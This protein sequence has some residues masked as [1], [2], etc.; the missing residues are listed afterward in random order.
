MDDIEQDG[1]GWNGTVVLDLGDEAFADAGLGGQFSECNIFLGAF[2][3]DLV[4]DQ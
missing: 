4:T 2:G 1:Q 3:L